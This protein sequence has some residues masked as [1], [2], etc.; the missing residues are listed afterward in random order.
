MK[1]LCPK[2]SISNLQKLTISV[3]ELLKIKNNLT[4]FKADGT[5]SADFKV[6]TNFKTL[7]SNGSL[8]V[9]NANIAHKSIP[10]R[11]NKINALVDFSNDNIKIKQSDVLVNE[12]PVKIKGTID[13]KA[14]GNILISANNLDLNHIMNAFP[15]L[16]P[17]KISL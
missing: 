5:I 12:Q 15:M 4:E 16:K 11:I 1:C 17:Q 8:K 9:N 10:L 13:S 7:H 14:N 3:L 6:Q 2:A